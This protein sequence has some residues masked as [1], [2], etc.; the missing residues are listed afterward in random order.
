MSGGR[1]STLTEELILAIS[2]AMS[3]GMYRDRAALSCGVPV[4]TFHRWFARGKRAKDD[5]PDDAIYRRLWQAVLESE[6]QAERKLVKVVYE[7]GTSNPDYALKYLEKKRPK[8]WGRNRLDLIEIKKELAK[9]AQEVRD[10][11]HAEDS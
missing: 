4:R 11:R 6:V 9:L 1:P 3:E 2:Q 10:Q 8:E 7:A 5:N